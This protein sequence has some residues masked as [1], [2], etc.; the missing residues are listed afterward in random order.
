MKK[1]KMLGIEFIEYK[2]EKCGYT[3][4]VSFKNWLVEMVRSIFTGIGIACFLGL[5]VL[6]L[7]NPSLLWKMRN[8]VM[9]LILNLQ[10]E[11]SRGLET[12]SI[13]MELTRDCYDDYCKAYK[14]YEYISNFTY[15]TFQ[16]AEPKEVLELKAGDCDTLAV[17]YCTLLR[18]LSIDCSV[19]TESE[20]KHSYTIVRLDNGIYLVDLTSKVF[21]PI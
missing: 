17:T 9:S 12:K 19:V 10:V 5:V 13:A 8:I 15:T 2:C 14:I 1:K 7:I 20:M 11:S 4:K 6:P 3:K 21:S 16:Y 18:E